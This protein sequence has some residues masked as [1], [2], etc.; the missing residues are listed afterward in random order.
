[1]EMHMDDQEKKSIDS[2]ITKHK[3]S[4]KA[5]I[6]VF[7]DIQRQQGYL[8]EE[9]VRYVAGKLTV[10]ASRA[11]AVATFYS[12]FSLVP[13]GRHTIHVCQGT[14]CHIQGAGRIAERISRH[15]KI[16]TDG[17]TKDGRFSLHTVRCLGCCA[18]APVV[19]VNDD[20][21]ADAGQDRLTAVLET[22][23]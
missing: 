17:R 19:K 21:H 16:G 20:I 18:L 5:L 8:S 6:A 22:Y 10:P 13:R 1:M 12:A 4:A 23:R 3:A 9:A 2:S 7:Q 11:F 15:L 14:A